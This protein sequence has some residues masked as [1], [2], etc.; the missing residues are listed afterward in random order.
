MKKF[1]GHGESIVTF[2]EVD[3]DCTLKMSAYFH[4]ALN[5]LTED[6]ER[7]FSWFAMSRRGVAPLLNYL[8]QEATGEPLAVG[9]PLETTHTVEIFR[10]SRE[11]LEPGALAPPDR[12]LLDQNVT[13]DAYRRSGSAFD[14][15]A[16]D[17]SGP[18]ITAG[19]VRIIQIFTRPHAAAG[20][21]SVTEIPHEFGALEE[22]P[23]QEDY[24]SPESLHRIPEG[25]AP[26]ASYDQ[27]SEYGVWGRG[28]TDINHHVTVTEY[29]RALEHN[30][31][32]LAGLAGLPLAH[33]HLERMRCLFRKPS[34]AGDG[35]RI[36]STLLRQGEA[37]CLHAELLRVG[38]DGTS[39]DNA[40]VVACLDGSM[41]D[42]P[43]VA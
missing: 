20:K 14:L 4:L 19:R 11:A 17:G 2:E 21:R 38:A 25:Y 33:C 7:H 8:E 13:I 34:F 12:L 31:Y 16:D 36:R 24:P 30:L 29:I 41:I 15:G 26:L 27:P 6:L 37:L 22:Q 3:L 32:L 23:W 18:R 1:T 10:Q 42:E 35:W 9:R 28:N 5:P 40:A 39:E 43:G